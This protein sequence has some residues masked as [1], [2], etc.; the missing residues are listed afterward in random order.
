MGGGLLQC[1]LILPWLQPGVAAYYIEEE[2]FQRFL[3]FANAAILRWEEETVETV[4]KKI[5]WTLIPWLKL[6]ENEN[7]P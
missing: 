6:G 7:G 1:P 3:I 5:C 4:R 2:P